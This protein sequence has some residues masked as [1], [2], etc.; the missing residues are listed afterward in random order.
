MSPFIVVN[1]NKK[2][3]FK[4]GGFSRREYKENEDEEVAKTALETRV[5]ASLKANLQNLAKKKARGVETDVCVL[6]RKS[7]FAC[8]VS[9]CR[10][11]RT[12]EVL[13]L[14]RMLGPFCVQTFLKM[15]FVAM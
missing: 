15:F 4:R 6:S 1:E 13:A 9:R 3:G 10:S 11:V 8:Y 12:N 14:A 7:K 2:K 5:N